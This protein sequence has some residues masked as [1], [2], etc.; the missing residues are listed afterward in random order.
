MSVGIRPITRAVTAVITVVHL[1]ERFQSTHGFSSA[2][3]VAA[4]IISVSM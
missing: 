4:A 1:I 3:I 2:I